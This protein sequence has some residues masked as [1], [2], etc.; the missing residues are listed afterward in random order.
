M[1]IKIKELKE[2]FPLIDCFSVVCD[3]SKLTTMAEYRALVT[4]GGID[5]LDIG[6]L[7]LNAGLG[8]MGPIDLVEDE[9]Y[10]AVW[11]VTGLH[12]VYLMKALAKQQMSRDKRSAV[13]F[14]SSTAAHMI[15]AGNASYSATKAMVSNFGES[16][17]YELR[18]NVDVTV[19]EPGVIE[20]NFHLARTPGFLTKTGE[21]AVS[22][23]LTLLGKER[24]T[25][26][27]LLFSLMPLP[28]TWFS[29]PREAKSM[30]EKYDKIM[31]KNVAKDAKRI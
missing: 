9:R 22:D 11:N 10:E 21:S 31:E 17:Y 29:G 2:Q 27:S 26:G 12:N 8:N 19:W 18:E 23:I 13:L 20:S 7:C 5:K 16:V 3:F 28:P 30:R 4:D 6:I 14:T 24:K 1:D 15:F 25:Y